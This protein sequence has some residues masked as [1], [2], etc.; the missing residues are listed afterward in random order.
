MALG[1]FFDMSTFL[2]IPAAF[3]LLLATVGAVSREMKSGAIFFFFGFSSGSFFTSFFT[4]FFTGDALSLAM[5]V[6]PFGNLAEPLRVSSL[7]EWI[8]EFPL[9]MAG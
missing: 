7:S 8:N 9:R 6:I 3:L 5:R 4:T 2:G 1:R